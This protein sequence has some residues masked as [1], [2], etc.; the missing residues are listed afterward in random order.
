MSKRQ[1]RDAPRSVSYVHDWFFD[2]YEAVRYVGPDGRMHKRMD[3]HGKIYGFDMDEEF[4]MKLRIVYGFLTIV[5]VALW[6]LGVFHMSTLAARL[7][8]AFFA[9]VAV[10][11]LFYIIGYIRFLFLKKEFNNREFH[12][13]YKRME[14]AA[15]VKAGLAGLSLLLCI[16]WFIFVDDVKLD[17]HNILTTFC[18]AAMTGIVALELFLINHNRYKVLRDKDKVVVNADP[19][20]GEKEAKKKPTSIAEYFAEAEEEDEDEE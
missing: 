6:V 11:E 3:Y 9:I 2:G 20:K 8:G 5:S 13:S 19:S 4:M 18:C 15:I 17:L 14:V 10:P 1:R 7:P 16:L 12:Q